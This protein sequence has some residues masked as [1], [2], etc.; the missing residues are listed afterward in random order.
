MNSHTLTRKAFYE[1]LTGYYV[2]INTRKY[3][4]LNEKNENARRKP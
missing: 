3:Y 2:I 4:P 1:E